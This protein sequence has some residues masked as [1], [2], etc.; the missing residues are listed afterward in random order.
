M[1]DKGL[2]EV[3]E[4]LL[5]QAARTLGLPILGRLEAADGIKDIWMLAQPLVTAL[6]AHPEFSEQFDRF[7]MGKQ[8]CYSPRQQAPNL[9][10]FAVREG[11]LKAVDWLRRI[12][13]VTKTDIRVI[14]KVYGLF[15]REP[16]RFSNGMTLLNVS[17]LPDSPNSESLKQGVVLGPGMAFPSALMM[18]HSDVCDEPHAEGHAKFLAVAR[19]MRRLAIAVTLSDDNASPIVTETWQEFADPDLQA[20]EIGRIWHQN[21][22]EGLIPD[23]G[24]N[25][26]EEAVAWVNRFVSLPTSV[27]APCEVPLT[28]L[29]MARRRHSAGDKALDGCIC[30]ESLLSGDGRGDLTHRVS[31][32]TALLL[33]K[34]LDERRNIV[35]S[36]KKFYELRSAVVHGGTEKNSAK[37]CAVASE[38]LRLCLLA[39]QE[40]VLNGEV[41][42]PSEWELSGGPSWNRPA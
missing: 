32:R 42:N 33:G 15:L 1:D 26:T 34:T 22:T 11:A 31:L 35:K 7:F 23:F 39:I 40:I 10:R 21:L 6:E 2:I 19:E 8:L 29:N 41:P 25:L 3:I 4:E 16:V 9:L 36:I 37:D 13:R 28:R 5:P 30:L 18:E 38:G 24:K 20:S 12:L 14:G 17:D 27:S